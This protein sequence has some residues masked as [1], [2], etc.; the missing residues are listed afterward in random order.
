MTFGYKKVITP[1]ES[2]SIIEKTSLKEIHDLSN[3]ITKTRGSLFVMG[4]L[5]KKIRKRIQKI[6]QV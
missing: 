4:D 1:K 6:W 2:K 3:L 5:N